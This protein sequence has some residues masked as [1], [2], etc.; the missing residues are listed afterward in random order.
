MP[1]FYEQRSEA[2]GFGNWRFAHAAC[3]CA[4]VATTL[5]LSVPSLAAEGVAGVWKTENSDS[6]G[7]LEVTIGPCESDADKTCGI[8]TAAYS[9][10]GPDL[11][12]EN[13]GKPI[14]K[15]M[16]S[17][18]GVSFHGGTVWDPEKDKIYKSKMKLEGDDLDVEGCISFIC[19][20]E[21]WKRLQ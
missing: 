9:P 2:P 1:A 13:L 8:I 15:D 10:E 6:G 17:K 7:H 5:F 11:D 12:Y 18:D 19:I 20:G 4:A 21:D 14:I 16:A 3:Y